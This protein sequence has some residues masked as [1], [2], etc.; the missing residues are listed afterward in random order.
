MNKNESSS[1]DMDAIVTDIL[2]GMSLKEKSLIANMD[3]K[4]LPYLQYAFDIY[5]SRQIGDD[6]DAG[7]KIMARVWR[8]LQD[9]HRIRLVKR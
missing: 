5:V 1:L 9:S 8:S 7:R 2:G 3:E 4:S 6:P